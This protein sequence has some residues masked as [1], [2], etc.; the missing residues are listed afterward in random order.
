[1]KDEEER[2][3]KEVTVTY[4]KLLFRHFPGGTEENHENLTQDNVCLD[5]DSKREG[6]PNTSRNRC[7]FSQFVR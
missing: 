4:F 5:L 6:L 2:M 7:R 3:R 1:M